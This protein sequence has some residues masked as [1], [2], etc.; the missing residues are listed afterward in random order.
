M[1]NLPGTALFLCI[2]AVAPVADGADFRLH[3]SLAVSEE[4]TDN[5]FETTSERTS[6]YITRV[7]PGLGG[8]YQAAALTGELNYVFD[9]R[10]Y[11]QNKHSD[12]IAH[13]LSAKGHLTAVENLMYLD[14]SD[15]Y[16]RVSL[17]ATRDVTQESLFINQVDRNVLTVSPHF[18]L[19]PAE[20]FPVKFGY[21]FVDT[22]YFGSE[23]IDKTDHIAFLNMAYELSKRFSLTADYLFTR[24]FADIDNFTQHQAL[25]GFRYEYADKSFL[26]AQAG[27]T[28]TRYDSGHSLISVAWNAG[29]THVLDTVTATVATG[30][31]YNDDPLR[32]VMKE[33]FVSGTLEKRFK[34]GMSSISPMFSEYV[35]TKTDILETRKYG[36]TLLGQYEFAADLNGTLSLTAEKYEQPLLDSY[37]RRI[38]A[39]SSLSY[40]VA[41][42]LL[43]SISYMYVGYY[44]PDIAYDNRHVNRVIVEIKK[45]F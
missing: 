1:T 42:Q 2:L 44:S 27:N 30:V 43:A 32:N 24:E 26:F 35:L 17:D 23:G 29:I 37:T 18:A 41:E 45:T 36:A 11:A 20:R 10:Y 15:E 34:R 33:K 40:L 16:Q 7:M 21:R 14:V 22:I 39:D 19:R 28:W 13:S 38:L 4:Y 25:G 6:A 3:P 9:Y 12:E 8:S 5:L 31:R